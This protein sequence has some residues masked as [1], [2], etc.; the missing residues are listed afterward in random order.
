MIASNPTLLKHKNNIQISPPLAL[1][2]LIVGAATGYDFALIGRVTI[3]EVIVFLCV[4]FFLFTGN[5]RFANRNFYFCLTLLAA[6][7]FGVIIADIINQTPF[8]FSARAFSRPIFILAYLLFFI[9]VLQKSMF[10]LVYYIYGRILASFIGIFRASEFEH[11][12]AADIFHYSGIVFRVQ[13]VVTAL[14]L[15]FAVWVYPKSRLSAIAAFAVG[16]FITAY[17]GGARSS[18]L[19]WGVA[20]AILIAVWFYK[21]KAS[22]RIQVTK[23]RVFQLAALV[24]FTLIGLYSFYLFGAP[25]G[26]LGETVQIKFEDQSM[27]VFGNSPLG[28]ILSGRPQVYGAILGIN[29]RPIIGFGSWRH[30]L[31]YVYTNEAIISVGVDPRMADRL[32]QSGLSAG[33]AGHSILF[34]A[35]VENGLVP[36]L[37]LMGVF[38]IF[39]RVL[40][41]SIR[42]ENQLTPFIILTVIAFMWNF[43]FSPPS[44][45][46]RL[47]AGMLMAFYVVFMD[48]RRPFNRVFVL[49]GK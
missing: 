21:N 17:I 26:H 25:R 30:D 39:I 9:V 27:T 40:F 8:L 49:S 22:R 12:A 16:A 31:T 2:M 35:W 4:P 46:F 23:T 24:T 3:A 45:G 13:P 1:L 36:A 47:A 19:I 33:G 7:F 38:I 32:A 43:I 11:E 44:I 14:I 34:Q 28:L 10:S 6:M 5:N 20:S 41:F 18:L 29:D 48:R 15:A 42:Y 37:A